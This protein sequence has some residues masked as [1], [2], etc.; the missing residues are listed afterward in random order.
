MPTPDNLEELQ[1]EVKDKVDE[2]AEAIKDG[3]NPD[4]IVA[5]I[6]EKD[7]KVKNGY[8]YMC[9]GDDSSFCVNYSSVQDELNK[10][11]GELAGQGGVSGKAIAIGAVIVCTLLIV[12]WYFLLRDD[13]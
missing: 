4:P 9:D 2:L 7:C 3:N 5:E 13:E 6:N 8:D 11:Y 10:S 1:N 12:M